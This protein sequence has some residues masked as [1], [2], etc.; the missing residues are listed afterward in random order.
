MSKTDT[1]KQRRVDV[2]LDSLE[3]KKELKKVAE[4]EDVSLSKFIQRCVEY[5]MDRGGP[6]LT[7]SGAAK[8]KVESLEEEVSELRKKLERKDKVIERLEDELRKYRLEQFSGEEFEGVREFDKELV[9]VLKEDGWHN[10]EEILR[11]LDIDPKDSDLVSA[12]RR[13][14]EQL[15]NYGLIR[16]GKMGWRWEG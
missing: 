3:R 14:L 16:S 13:Q 2:Y 5:A 1:I 7:E 15:E 4:E 11:R 6:D 12:V 9:E 8:K 10:D